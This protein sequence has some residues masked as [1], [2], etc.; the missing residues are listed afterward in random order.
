M[1]EQN[2][3]AL[4]RRAELFLE[5]KEWKLA[6]DYY[7]KVLDADPENARAYV[8]QLLAALELSAESELVHSKEPFDAN[9]FYEKAVRF[10]DPDYK[11]ILQKYNTDNVYFRAQTI[12]KSAT[13]A[14]DFAKAKELL[15]KIADHL[16]VTDLVNTCV[17][18]ENRLLREARYKE[19]QKLMNSDDIRSIEKAI[20]LFQ[21]DNS[22]ESAR[23]IEK[24]KVLIQSITEKEK[25]KEKKKKLVTI[26]AVCAVVILG[27]VA[28][29]AV[30]SANQKKAA[31]NER[32]AAEIYNKF[33]GTSFSNSS[34]DDDGFY[35]DYKRGTLND[36]KVY[37]KREEERTLKFN[38]NGTVEYIYTYD[39]VVLA[40]PRN[41]TPPDDTH[42]KDT[43]VF[44]SFSVVYTGDTAYLKFGGLTYEISVTSS[45]R[46]SCIKNFNGMNLWED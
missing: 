23:S 34:E 42:K 26:A 13:V 40:Y 3:P 37:R 7:E 35:N 14:S 27:I 19:A 46:P 28:I 39:S 12:L 31:E 33:L 38:K 36:Y 44:D 20:Q 15:Q 11:A 21:M 25:Q 24:C 17:A 32:I 18:E 10:A 5:D 4:L 9:K 41:M 8:G 22:E 6:S 16:D 1:S 45:N 30:Q 2:I 43:H 29:F